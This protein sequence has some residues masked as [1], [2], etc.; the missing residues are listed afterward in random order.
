MESKNGGAVPVNNAPPSRASKWLPVV[1]AKLIKPHGVR[2]EVK[3][4]LYF[5][6]AVEALVGKT[7]T[8]APLNESLPSFA[9]PLKSVKGIGKTCRVQLGGVFTPE[10]AA[11][12]L[13]AMI[14]APKGE[15]PPLPDGQ[16]YFEEIIDLPVVTPEGELLGRLTDFFPAGEA[17]VW[18]ITNNQGEERMIPCLPTT[19]INVD[20][21]NET[22]VMRPLEEF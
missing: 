1:V 12:Y 3:V 14:I 8:V 15:I 18:T 20:L 7:V 17:D 9:A 6:E 2:G 13:P 4:I 10:D 16:Y 19:L 11:P 22:I 5:P 21:E